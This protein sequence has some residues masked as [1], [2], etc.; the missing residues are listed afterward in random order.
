MKIGKKENN[1]AAQTKKPGKFKLGKP[2]I[3]LKSN[4]VRYGGYNTVV[5]VVV[6][7]ILVVVNLL[8][9]Q[10]P[11]KYISID[12]SDTSVYSLGDTTEQVVSSLDLDVTIYVL[13]DESSSDSVVAELLDRYE[14]LSDHISVKYVDTAEN[15][16]FAAEYDAS[17]ATS[18]SLIVVSEKRSTLVDYG[19]IYE[20]EIDYYTYYTTGEYS[21]TESFDGESLIT[22]AIDYVASDTLPIMYTLSGHGEEDLSDDITSQVNKM[23]IETQELSLLTEGEIPEDASAILINQPTQDLSDDEKDLLLTYM[24]EGGSVLYIPVLQ[25]DEELTNF[26]EI[27]SYYGIS[28]TGTLVMESDTSMYYQYPYMLIPSVSS[29]SDITSPISDENLSILVLQAQGIVTSDDLRSSVSLTNLMTTSENAYAKDISSGSLSTMDKEDGDEEGSFT[30]AVSAE[31]EIDD[32]TSTKLVVIS[33]EY[34]LDDSIL[35]SFSVGNAD[36]FLNSVSWMCEHESTISISSKDIT[37]A[38]LVV[39]SSAGA[40]LRAVTMVILPVGLLLI[41]VVV[42]IRRRKK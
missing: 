21:A 9:E 23:N 16:S 42:W 22:S 11:S 33:S 17:S 24:Q 35:S 25:P 8:V 36:L 13:I 34:I 37:E 26:A 15:P 7:A 19:D 5:A 41:G 28:L 6:L 31:E 18:N 10:L 27:L 1:A 32:D 40:I 12:T 3:N 14:D 38:S 4:R 39:S 30:L 2:H 29:S 20:S